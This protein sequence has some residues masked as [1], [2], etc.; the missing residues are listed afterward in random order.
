MNEYMRVIASI[1]AAIRRP[2][3]ASKV[4]VGPELLQISAW[5]PL[6]Y[7]G[8]RR[9]QSAH[10]KAF[11]EYPTQHI[12]RK[13]DIPS[14]PISFEYYLPAYR[15]ILPSSAPWLSMQSKVVADFR[16]GL[17]RGIGMIR[18]GFDYYPVRSTCRLAKVRATT[19]VTNQSRPHW[20]GDNPNSPLVRLELLWFTQ[21]N[22]PDECGNG[23]LMY[24][25]TI[26]AP[27]TIT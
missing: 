22:S 1:R 26:V 21:T 11:R 8:V 16:N 27:S 2:C 25:T 17:P 10:E 12:T 5:P 24:A 19:F 13:S 9:L 23:G 15:S 4:L 7:V 14:P 20:D 18:K 6:R 3:S